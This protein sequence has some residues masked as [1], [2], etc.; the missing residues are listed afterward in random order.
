MNIMDFNQGIIMTRVIEKRLLTKAQIDR[1]IDAEDSEEV[2]K[3]LRETEYSSSFGQMKDSYDYESLLSSE[4]IRVYDLMRDIS[5]EDVVID[6]LA[7]KY[8]YH[9][10]R[11]MIKEKEL[12]EDLSYLYLPIGATDFKAIKAAYDEG[13]KSKIPKNYKEAID[14]VVK[15]YAES[16]DPQKIDIILD[17]FYYRHLYQMAKESE[18]KF[19][20]QYV[21][22]V[23]D[24]T[25]ISSVIRLIRQGRDD[26][27]FDDIMLSDGNI[28]KEKLMETVKEPLELEVLEKEFSDCRIGP[29]LIKGLASYK[30]TNR[31]T[32]FEKCKDDYLMD[33]NKESK[34]VLFGPEP[35]FSYVFAK[36]TE[37]KNLRIILVSKVNNISSH[38]IRERVRDLYV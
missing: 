8:D 4:L 10:L 6:L 28:D 7:L 36:E 29:S 1:M 33:I 22:D 26:K 37:I 14:A 25:N 18:I 21:E 9:N 5:V 16:L 13:D 23:I 11:V 15:E 30:E 32:D 27:H 20:I 17:K 2:L 31:L 12:E 38:V 19:F 24:F 35:L 34:R 3:I